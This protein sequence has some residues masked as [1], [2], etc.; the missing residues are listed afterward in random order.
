MKKILVVEDNEDI[1]HFL[2]E[3]LKKEN[4]STQLLNN[5]LEVVEYLL[6]KEFIPDAVILDLML[7]GRSGYEL[8]NT[9][10]SVC[11]DVKIFIFSAHREYEGR[12]PDESAEG[13]FCKTDGINKL[14]NALKSSLGTF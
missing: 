6:K 1:A 14:V 13:F 12:I 10:K 3:K 8:L 7:P 2:V 9:I 11:P 5:G 4:Y